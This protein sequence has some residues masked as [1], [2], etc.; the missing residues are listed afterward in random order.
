MYFLSIWHIFHHIYVIYSTNSSISKSTMCKLILQTCSRWRCIVKGSSVVCKISLHMVFMK[1]VHSPT[2]GHV[3]HQ[4]NA[5]IVGHV[6]H[7]K[8]ALIIGHVFHQKNALIIRHV[9]HQKMHWLSDTYSTK[10]CINYP[11][12]IPPKKCINYPTCIPP[13]MH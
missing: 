13:K 4:K 2:I 6:F 10:K 1:Q 5:L 7:Q 12:C 11:T 8:N 3:F 9:F